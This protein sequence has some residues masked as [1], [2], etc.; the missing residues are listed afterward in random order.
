MIP[1]SVRIFVCTQPQDMRRSFDMLALEAQQILGEDPQSG[2]MFVFTNRRSNQLKVLWWDRNG[3]CLLYKRLHRA[4]F[5][6]P[7][8]DAPEDRSVR[9]DRAALGEL[10]Y[11]VATPRCRGERNRS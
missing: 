1:S 7:K 10:L 6:L 5:R 4:L 2:A 8:S 3:Y 9:I 11:G